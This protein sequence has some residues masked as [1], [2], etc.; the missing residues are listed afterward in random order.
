MGLFSARCVFAEV[1]VA[2]VGQLSLAF[3]TVGDSTFIS[4][5]DHLIVTFVTVAMAFH[6]QQEVR[7]RT[8]ILTVS[9]FVCEG[10]SRGT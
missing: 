6:L 2:V 10:S 9:V 7:V 5:R 4:L 8:F 3:V 1:A